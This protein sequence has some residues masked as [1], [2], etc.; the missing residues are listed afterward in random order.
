VP[1]TLRFDTDVD[2]V[3]VPSFVRLDR[4]AGIFSTVSDF[5]PGRAGVRR[6][7]IVRSTLRIPQIKST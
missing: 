2:D 5:F 7:F 1:A 6:F 3:S 4:L